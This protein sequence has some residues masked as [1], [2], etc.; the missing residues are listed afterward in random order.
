MWD[1]LKPCRLS[2]H[3]L[4][5][6]DSPK[7]CCELPPTSQPNQVMSTYRRAA[8]CVLHI[9]PQEM[10]RLQEENHSWSGILRVKWKKR[11]SIYITRCV[12][13][14][15]SSEELNRRSF[16]SLHKDSELFHYFMLHYNVPF[17]DK[18]T[19]IKCLREAALFSVSDICWFTFYL[20]TNPVCVLNMQLNISKTSQIFILLSIKQRL[21]QAW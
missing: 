19:I 13:S 12:Q 15:A 9:N 6:E 7:L 21:S 10:E 1:P 16:L 3:L 17:W 4:L 11:H 20:A 18:L 2:I 14:E 5:T 8:G